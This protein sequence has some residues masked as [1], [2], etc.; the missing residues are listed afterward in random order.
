[1]K[2]VAAAFPGAL[3][4]DRSIEGGWAISYSAIP[5][6]SGAGIDPA[7]AGAPFEPGFPDAGCARHVPFVVLDIPLLFESGGEKSVDLV[8]V[9][10]AAGRSAPACSETS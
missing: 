5:C 10:T 7:P 6:S 8:I 2:P 1:V 4:G 9:V 3:S